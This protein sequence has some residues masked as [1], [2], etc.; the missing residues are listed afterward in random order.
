MTPAA[1][2]ERYGV[3]PAALPRARRDRRGDLRQPARGARRRPGLRR[4]VAH[5][6]RR[7]RRRHRQRRQ[8]HRQEGRVAA[9]APRRR[10][11]QPAA[12]RAGVRPRPAAA[13][14]RTSRCAPGT[15]RRCTR[16]S[17]AWSSGCCATGCSR[18]SRRRRR[19]TTAASSWPRPAPRARHRRRRGSPSTPPRTTGSA[20]RS[21]APGAPGTGDVH[22]VALA[23]AAGAAWVDTDDGRPRRTTQ[24][25]AAWLADADRPKVM[26]DAK[27][28]ML[29]LAARGWPVSGL[30][31]RH[32]ALG[33]PLP[34]RP[35][36]LRPGRPHAALPQARAQGRAPPTT[37]S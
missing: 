2:E 1:V 18:P 7:S 11:A 19:S 35:A 23:T 24:A 29:A 5:P 32:R 27:G 36:L 22:A 3:P 21:R 26:H 20:S 25:L 14:A 9:R 31:P 28:P 37:A 33:V 17:T 6:V 16:S 30:D 10:D 13:A 8:D 4:Q 12:Q 34:A 15:A